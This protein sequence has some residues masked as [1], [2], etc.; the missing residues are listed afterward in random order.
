MAGVLGEDTLGQ[1]PPQEFT[2]GRKNEKAPVA[3]GGLNQ[4]LQ[5]G[6]MGTRDA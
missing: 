6:G 5:E 1:L 3:S 4:T 2:V